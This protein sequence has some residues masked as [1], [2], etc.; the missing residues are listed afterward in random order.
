MKANKLFI[1]PLVLMFF[2]SGCASKKSVFFNQEIRDN[3]ES[4]EI[5]MTEIQFYNSHKIVLE[6][7]LTYEE[8]KVAS[9]KIRFENGQFI[10]R[11]IIKKNTPG[12]CESFTEDMIDVAFEQGDNRVLKFVRDSESKFRVSA[13][14]W[15]DKYGKIA[16]DTTH[17]FIA[18]GGEKAVLKVKLE[19]IYNFKKQERVAPGR[20]VT[21]K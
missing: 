3:V 14:E 16:Y 9:G 4:Y 12:V 21:S 1:L 6:R 13:L 7:N 8:T 18:P 20:S 11:I 5:E 15:T 10:E 19:D 17:F 2:F